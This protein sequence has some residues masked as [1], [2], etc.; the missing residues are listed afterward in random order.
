MNQVLLHRLKELPT[1]LQAEV[2]DFI[3]FLLQKKRIAEQGGRAGVKNQEPYL[4]EKRQK[5]FKNKQ[6]KLGS[7]KGTFTMKP[8]FDEPLDD[9]AA[10]M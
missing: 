7:G 2:L 5:P 9:F 3:E 8:G 1:D 6:P 4:M 10:Y